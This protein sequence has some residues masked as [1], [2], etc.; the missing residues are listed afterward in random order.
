MLML[1]YNY[2]DELKNYDIVYTNRFFAP[3]THGQQ[4]LTYVSKFS[5]VTSGVFFVTNFTIFMF[6]FQMSM[7][8]LFPS[9]EMHFPLLLQFVILFFYIN[10][11]INLHIRINS[12][13][14][15]Q[16]DLDQ[17]NYL[18]VQSLKLYLVAFVMI[19]MLSKIYF[20]PL[21]SLPVFFLVWIPQIIKNVLGNY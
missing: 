15:H 11:H 18:T 14:R 7:M 8:G 17:Q 4:A 20:N 2:E 3:E 1:M 19:V 16:G 12:M 10:K 6:Y 9:F 13:D 5:F 21:F